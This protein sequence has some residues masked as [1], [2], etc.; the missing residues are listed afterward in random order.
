MAL[1]L[2][3]LNGDGVLSDAD[4]N[5]HRRNYFQTTGDMHAQHIQNATH[6]LGSAHAVGQSLQLMLAGSE[7]ASRLSGT[8]AEVV[9]HL[10][11]ADVE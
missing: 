1:P 3:D 7:L 5:A 9:W 2:G 8:P 4:A 11:K 10:L 6:M